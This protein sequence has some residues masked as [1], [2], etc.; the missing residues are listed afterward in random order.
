MFELTV[1]PKHRTTHRVS[2]LQCMLSNHSE[3]A[4][5]RIEVNKVQLLQSVILHTCSMSVAA[6]LE[7][8]V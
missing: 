5:I 8:R 2:T 7:S 1:Y 3:H 4:S 6:Y